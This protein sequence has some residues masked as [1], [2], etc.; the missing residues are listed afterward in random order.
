MTRQKS[1]VATFRNNQAISKA[2]YHETAQNR[3]LRY[4]LKSLHLAPN[5]KQQ[6]AP[7][8][9]GRLLLRNP[10]PIGSPTG[11]TSE[12]HLARFSEHHLARF[13]EHHL[14]PPRVSIT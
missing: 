8:S 5:S 13:S 2:A 6:T 4:K 14:R 12:H 1:T 10:L 7:N 3:R 9:E 11:V